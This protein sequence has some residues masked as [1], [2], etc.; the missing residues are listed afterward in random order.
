MVHPMY[1]RRVLTG[2]KNGSVAAGRVGGKP[3]C[4]VSFLIPWTM[5]VTE[6]SW[7]E[8]SSAENIL[9]TIEYH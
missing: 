4:E 6:L 5:I 7:K 8:T 9:C 2:L 3:V 1:T